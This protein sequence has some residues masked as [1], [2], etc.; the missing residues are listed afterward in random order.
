MYVRNFL[1]QNKRRIRNA[2]FVKELTVL[3]AG[4]LLEAI[5][6]SLCK[7]DNPLR[8]LVVLWHAY[9]S[10]RYL[11]IN[12]HAY[13][14]KDILLRLSEDA[15]YARALYTDLIRN[16]YR[17]WIKHMNNEQPIDEDI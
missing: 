1:D 2:T 15:N 9:M 4:N 6:A 3:P 14:R 10:K 11:N 7:E 13:E 12:K 16:I 5:E 8:L 17:D